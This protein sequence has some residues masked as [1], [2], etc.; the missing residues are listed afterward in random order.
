MHPMVTYEQVVD[1]SAEPA[2]VWAVLADVTTWPQWTPTMTEVTV[3]SPDRTLRVGVEVRIRQPRLPAATWTVQALEPGVSFSW[4]SASAGTWNVAEHKVAA[5]AGG[6]SQITLSFVHGG[7]LSPLTGLLLGR[8]MSG[9]V[10]TEARSLQ[11]RLGPA[12]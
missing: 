8:L 11:Q 6:G 3:R 5:R 2:A 10:A 9:Y 4:R 12:A 1:V 7:P